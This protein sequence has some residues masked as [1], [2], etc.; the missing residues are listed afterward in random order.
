MDKKRIKLI[1]SADAAHLENDIN[2]W[3]KENESKFDIIEINN[4]QEKT[5]GKTWGKKYFATIF[6]SLK[7]NLNEVI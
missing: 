1:G 4:F 3:I 5:A 6:Y 2:E 7:N